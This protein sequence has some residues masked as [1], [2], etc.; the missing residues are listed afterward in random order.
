M[1]WR[2]RSERIDEL[3]A[4]LVAALGELSDVPKDREANAGTYRYRYADL[5]S[6]LGQARPILAAHGLALT[7]AAEVTDRV[8]SVWTTIVHTSGQY[9]TYAPTVL[10]VGANPQATGSA[11][12]YARRYAAMAVLGL[13]TEDDDGAAASHTPSRPTRPVAAP[14]A[15]TEA[16][17]EIRDLLAGLP[18]R[19]RAQARSE[20]I[21]RWGSNLAGLDVQHHDDAL[22]WVSRLVDHLTIPDVPHPDATDS[23][24]D[25]ET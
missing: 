7:Q 13:A 18:D 8:V 6:T 3:A 5:A 23:T 10:P 22:L 25:V 24:E 15:R 12:T 19:E 16:E 14:P 4:A 9:V 20:F 2:D 21:A 11:I 1:M 17:R